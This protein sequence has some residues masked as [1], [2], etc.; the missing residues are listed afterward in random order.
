[1]HKMHIHDPARP[2]LKQL[3][4]LLGGLSVAMLTEWHNGQ[5]RSRPMAALE[6]DSE[7][8]FWFLAHQP[9]QEP[10]ASEAA[11]QAVNLNFSDERKST[12]VSMS[13]HLVWTTDRAR[14]ES[15]WTRFAKPWFPDGPDT[16]GLAALAFVPDNAEYWDSPSSSV[17]R[18]FAMAASIAGAKPVGLGQH[19]S[20]RLS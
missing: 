16:P 8:N 14:I 13:G 17:V 1:M 18:L 5:L 4:D 15:L 10:P 3:A 20:M 11:P 6:L 7:G 19:G 9:A 12:Y 2:E